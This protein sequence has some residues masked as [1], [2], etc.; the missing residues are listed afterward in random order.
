MTSA[1]LTR[2]F[3]VAVFVVHD[4]KVL[5]HFHQK[6][7]RWLPPGGH[8]D[9]NELPDEAAVREVMEE[10]GVACTLLRGDTLTFDDPTLPVQLVTP[11][12]IQLEQ[13]GPGHQHI[14][15]IYYAIG[16]PAEARDQVGWYALDALGPLDLTEEITMRCALAI[17]SVQHS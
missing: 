2:D 13:I 9:P 10:T 16:A 6:L 7:Q 12:G 17:E 1:L 3:T 5:L 4:G 11:V 15:L 8:I 14:D